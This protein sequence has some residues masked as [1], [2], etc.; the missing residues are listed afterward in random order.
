MALLDL[1]EARGI[2]KNDGCILNYYGIDYEMCRYCW[3]KVDPETVQG[4][5]NSISWFPLA[6]LEH[7]RKT[8]REK[9]H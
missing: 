3:D 4:Y 9:T 1:G 7:L 2:K 8:E 5:F 6:S